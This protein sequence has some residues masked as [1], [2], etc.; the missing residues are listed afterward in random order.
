MAQLNG[1][2]VTILQ[3]TGGGLS[4]GVQP[5][6]SRIGPNGTISQFAFDSVE[7]QFGATKSQADVAFAHMD[8]NDRGSITNAEF[9]TAM[10]NVG[11]GS[12]ASQALLSLMDSNNDRSV[13]STEFVKFETAMVSAEKA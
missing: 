10:G 3:V 6:G 8:V 2:G 11:N 9:L 5:A 7:E 13:S 12:A 4:S 1:K